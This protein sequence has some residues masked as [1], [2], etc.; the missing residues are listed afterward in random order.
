MDNASPQLSTR[1]LV[2]GETYS[3]YRDRISK[4]EGYR[5]AIYWVTGDVYKGEWSNDKR[6]GTGTHL[7]KSGNRYEGQFIEGK[8]EG[9][10]TFWILDN[11]TKTYCPTYRGHW[12]NNLWHGTGLLYGLSGEVYVGSFE[13]GKR[14]GC[15][16]QTYRHWMDEKDTYHVYN[17]E[18]AND[19]RNGIGT[20]T[21]VNGN[22]YIGHWV[23]DMKEGLGVFYYKEKESKYEG[24]WKKDVPIAGTYT[25]EV[26]WDPFK[27]M[28]DVLQLP[29]MEV[30]NFQKL[31]QDCISA[32]WKQPL[33]VPFKHFTSAM[34]ERE[35]GTS[36]FLL[37]SMQATGAVTPLPAV[38]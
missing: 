24:V 13:Y 1:D 8:R 15:G 34:L 4:K 21:M 6:H 5:V 35:E 33:P 37:P 14:S 10:G 22:V 7:Y 29:P 12:K 32:A 20:L 2:G 27:D 36:R 3:Q 19:K 25:R 16:K 30:A 17:G 38:S 23:D 28:D 31:A 26:K 18:W 11:S 9:H